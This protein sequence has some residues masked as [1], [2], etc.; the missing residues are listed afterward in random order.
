MISG[1]LIVITYGA[2]SVQVRL[3]AEGALLVVSN[4]S[5]SVYGVITFKQKLFVGKWNIIVILKIKYR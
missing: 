4:N 2:V 3:F 5:R 1:L